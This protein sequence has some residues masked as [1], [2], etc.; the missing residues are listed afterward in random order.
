MGQAKIGIGHL[1]GLKTCKGIALLQLAEEPILQNDLQL[2]RV[3]DGFLQGGYTEK[4]ISHLIEKKERFFIE[5]ALHLLSRRSKLYKRYFAF[6]RAYDLPSNV[7]LP[8]YQRG[9][10]VL[11]DGT[12]KWYKKQRRSNYREFIHKLTPDFLELP[13]DSCWSFPDLCAF[14]ESEKKIS[15][16]V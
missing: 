10:C 11:N 3:C 14:I 9:F 2:T 5:S 16:Y 4:D 12:V 1:Y 8:L 6:D 7:E 15:E 13:L